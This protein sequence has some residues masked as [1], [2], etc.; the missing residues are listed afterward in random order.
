MACI[1]DIR[2]AVEAALETIVPNGAGEVTFM[3]CNWEERYDSLEKNYRN[4]DQ[5]DFAQVIEHA[6]RRGPN[7]ELRIAVQLG[8][9]GDFPEDRAE[10]LAVVEKRKQATQLVEDAK[11]QAAAM[12]A[13]A[14]A[15]ASK[16]LQKEQGE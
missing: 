11:R 13:Q 15:E 1:N 16:I 7:L 4:L 2:T 5:T 9:V 12:V 14:E 3:L 6:T 8:T 10:A